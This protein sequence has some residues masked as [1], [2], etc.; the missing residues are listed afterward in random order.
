MELRHLRYFVAVAEEQN[1]S[2]AAKRLHVSQPPLSRQI[3]DLETELGVS[4]FERD[5][6]SVKL[7]QLGELFLIEARAALQRVEHAAAFIQA[8]ARRADD[9][10]RIAHTNAIAVEVLP[11]LLSTIQRKHERLRIEVS[12]STKKCIVEGLQSGAF[13]LGLIIGDK[14]RK[15]RGLCC[16]QFASYQIQVAAHQGHRFANLTEIPLVEFSKERAIILCGK[17]SPYYSRSV[18]SLL[19]PYRPFATDPEEYIDPLSGLASIEAGRGVAICYETL[20]KVAGERVILR[21]LTPSPPR[22]PALILYRKEGST[23]LMADFVAAA[24]S[25]KDLPKSVPKIFAS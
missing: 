7:T 23:A 13:D 10:I 11:L 25:L 18:T 4:L 2:R 19:K 21:P 15:L 8:V 6:K 3:R 1:I 9:H 17:D 20:A 12:V 22:I 5:A 24:Q 16:E 14:P